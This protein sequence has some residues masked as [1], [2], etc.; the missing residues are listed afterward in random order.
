MKRENENKP[1]FNTELFRKLIEQLFK[2]DETLKFDLDKDNLISESKWTPSGMM[3]V[4]VKKILR[5]KDKI[6]YFDFDSIF[7]D[8]EKRR[9]EKIISFY[10]DREEK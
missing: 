5:D 6:K 3:I 10:E 7:T 1:E 9:I 8:E 4:H 2:I